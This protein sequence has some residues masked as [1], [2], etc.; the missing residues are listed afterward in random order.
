[1]KL[2]IYQWGSYLQYDIFSICKEKNI[3]FQIFE[4]KFENKNHDEKF[5]QWFC[6]MVKEGE[7]DALLSVNYFPVLSDVCMKRKIKYIAWCYDNPLNVERIEETLDNPVNYVFLFD[8]MQFWQYVQKGFQTVYHLPLGVNSSRLMQLK[9]SSAECAQYSAEVSFVGNL[10]KSLIHE[11]MELM[12]DYTRGYLKSLMDVQ[13][14]IYGQYIF[15]EIITQELIDNING[16]YLR[17]NPDTGLRLSKPALTFAMASEVTRN[18]RLVLLSLCGKRFDTKLYSNDD[19]VVIK[20]VTKCGPVDYVETMP[21][22]FT[23]SKINLNPTLRIIQ[24]GIPLRAFDIMGAGGF[25]LSNYQEELLEHFEN[26]KHLVIYESMEDAIEKIG[27]YLKHEER[28]C[29]IAENGKK[30]T[31]E[32]YSLQNCMERIFQT[33]GLV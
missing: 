21:K 9:V 28:R 8:K 11:L 15:D 25:L 13:L 31:L 17:Q 16:Q 33:A 7:Y 1:M 30:R 22:V 6:N 4:W 3:Y 27:F 32:E 23:C 19:S 14:Q 2:L 5:E 12:D 24:T 20:N 10:Y 26:E 18:E 29:Q